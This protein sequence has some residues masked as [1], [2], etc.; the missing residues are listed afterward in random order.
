MSGRIV[1]CLSIHANYRCRHSGACC[2]AG[3]PIQDDR[4]GPLPLNERG[5][6][7]HNAD[8]HRCEIQL[9]DGHDALPL[10]CRQFP[11][12]SLTDPTGTSVTL[13]HFCPTALAMLSEHD[14]PITIVD[15]A[16]AFPAT[17]EYVG[18]DARDTLPPLLRPG[19][20]MD[21]D[22]WR[23]WERLSIEMF[24]RDETPAAVIGRL[25]IA[26]ELARTGRRPRAR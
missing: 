18:L 23:E 1:R 2:T 3:W 12:V 24:N 8:A 14:G 4:G 7:F 16:P 17:G 11:R 15:D 22:S 5:C 21:W 25:A 19:M 13:S 6:V 20:L 10:A 26:V 9:A